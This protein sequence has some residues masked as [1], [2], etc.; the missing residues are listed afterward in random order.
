MSDVEE[1]KSRLNIVD[2][3]Q[4]RVPLK[5]AG[6]NFKGLCPFHSEKS[7]SF[8]VS[9][10]RQAFHCFGCGKGGS[11]IDFVMEMEHLSFIEALEDLAEKAGVKLTHK[12]SDSQEDQ[13]RQKIYE[14]NHLASEYYQYVLTKHALGEKAR[15]YLKGRGVTDKTMKTF[16]LGYSPN[17][18]DALGSFL[19]KKGYDAG[20]LEK[21]GLQILSARGGYDRFRGRVMFTLKDH[22]GNVVGFS[23]RLLDPNI[24]DLPAGRQEAKYINTSETP[25][26]SK[27][28]VLYG[29]DVTREAIQ[30]AGE[31]IIVEGEF[32]VISPF[33]EGIGNV[34]AIKGSALT[35]GHIRLLKRY[36]QKLV[37]AL[38][39]DLAGDAAARR[40]I[41]LADAAGLELKVATMPIGKD[42]DEAARESPGALKSAIKDAVPIY[43]YYIASVQKRFDPSSASGKKHIAGEL[44]PILSKI[45]N[46]IVQ[47][48]YIKIASRLLSVSEDVLGSEIRKLKVQGARVVVSR[49]KE[50]DLPTR[51]RVETLEM[52]VLALM[53]QGKPAE[54]LEEFKEVMPLE[55]ITLPPV[56]RLIELLETFMQNH[57]IFL[58][59]DFADVVPSELAPVLDE[60]LLW[61]VSEATGDEEKLSKEWTTA[62]RE[63]KRAE[64]RRKIANISTTMEAQKLQEA[65]M[66]GSAEDANRL[67]ELTAALLQLDKGS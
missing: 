51:S 6:R 49:E 5:K 56:R 28:H 4:A 50:E 30:K 10:E 64:L 35:E 37:L 66:D 18:W 67:A 1:V 65:G 17:S 23:G 15:L 33:A 20:L 3:V 32:D 36:T 39:S 60:A 61:D 12:A 19:K 57:R 27:S 25:V 59:K 8:M 54:F 63:L 29:L 7:P 16:A 38:D 46:S 21:A 22:R 26:Y 40:G 2:I 13:Q 34:V 48:H 58:L 45:E 31:A 24:K 14:V 11:V 43:D 47:A 55:D 9:P 53:L 44:L 41:E 52:Y 62:L 42:P